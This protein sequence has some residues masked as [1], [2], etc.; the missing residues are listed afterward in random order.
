MKKLFKIPA[1]STS[2]PP[3]KALPDQEAVLNDSRELHFARCRL[4]TWSIMMDLESALGPFM[5]AVR[6][7]NMTARRMAFCMPYWTNRHIDTRIEIP[8][9]L[10]IK[11]AAP[12]PTTLDKR[13]LN[14][15]AALV[16][17]A[18]KV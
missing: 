4:G 1:R 9:L 10:Q 3:R 15:A 17:S 12:L 2:T 5:N 6:T 7:T 18:E 11:M 14:M 16:P 13:W 8:M